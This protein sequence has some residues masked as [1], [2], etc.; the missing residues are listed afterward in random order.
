MQKTT[1]QKIKLGIMVLSGVLLFTLAVYLIGDKQSLFQKNFEI[2]SVFKSVRGLRLGDNVRYLGIDAGNV[3]AIEMI[4]DTA[5]R[6][7]MKLDV[8]TMKFIKKNA[9]AKITTDGLVGDMV[10]N[11]E[12]GIGFSKGIED[13]DE[14]TAFDPVGTAEILS[15]LSE[16]NEN[17]AMLTAGILRITNSINEGKGTLGMLIHDSETADDIRKIIRNVKETTQRSAVLMKNLEDVSNLIKS[18]KNLLGILLNDT[19]S[20]QK[21]HELISDLSS[22][23]NEIKKM[24]ESLN[25]LITD[26][27][28]GDNSVMNTLANDSLL[29]NDIKETLENIN[30]GSQKFNEN[31]EALKHHTL[32][33]GYFKDK[34]KEKRKEK[35]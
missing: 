22:S 17:A 7:T 24:S 32:F 21:L 23:G 16:T 30:S 1:Y 18:D 5:I 15:T 29:R 25:G 9:V 6:I 26:L 19:L 27:A 3:K 10:V 31:M 13:K 33:K 28:E 8:H 35:K 4:N 34:E 2:S 12:P 14:I 11:I 20:A